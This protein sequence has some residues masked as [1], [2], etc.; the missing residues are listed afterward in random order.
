MKHAVEA[1]VP[2][3]AKSGGHSSWSTI[4]S[5]GFVLDLGLLR[6][7]EVDA[8]KKLAV[9]S[10]GARIADVHAATCAKGFCG[11]RISLRSMIH[12]FWAQ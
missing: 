12:L 1:S 9:I 8:D 7:V 4:G 11:G 5:D 10:A 2:F 6:G 3:V